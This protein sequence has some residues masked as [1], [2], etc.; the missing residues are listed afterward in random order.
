[1]N[2][3]YS[4]SVR[5]LG[6]ENLTLKYG[7]KTILN[8]V[9]AEIMNLHRPGM[10]QG[11]VIALLGP[12]G[13]GKTQLFRCMAGSSTGLQNP[14]SIWGSRCGSAGVPSSKPS[15]GNG[16]LA[17]IQEGYEGESH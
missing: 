2:H 1:M 8:N 5:L 11:Q 10:H 9:N 6:V 16:Q 14:G 3:E 7:P 17:H 4:K 12:S 13:C 15:Y